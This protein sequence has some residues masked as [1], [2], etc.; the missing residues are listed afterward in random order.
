MNVKNAAWYRAQAEPCLARAE[1]ATDP[2]IK[3][4]NR[5]EA[6]RWLRLAELAEKQKPQDTKPEQVRKPDDEG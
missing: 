5:A 4:F 6:E 2:R 3:E 1:T